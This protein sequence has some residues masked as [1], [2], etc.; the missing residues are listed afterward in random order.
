MLKECD[1][2]HLASHITIDDQ[3]P[4]RSGILLNKGGEGEIDRYIRASEIAP[5]RL[6][7]RMAVISGC[8]SA[9][10]KVLSGEGVLGLTSAFLSAKVPVVISSLWP[11][12]DSATA[13]LMAEFYTYL[14]N[15][16]TAAKSLRLAQRRMMDD[17]R[18]RHAFY[19]AGFVVG[20][21]GN[22]SIPLI[23]K[24]PERLFGALS[25]LCLIAALSLFF[26][27]RK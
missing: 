25:I 20:G 14:S 9:G 18:T 13:S 17:P 8:E 27:R 26:W 3:H 6:S 16:E 21:E 15:G 23:R 4:W 22:V 19:W 11:V 2:L 1:L 24:S 5:L 12:D 10:G 7:A